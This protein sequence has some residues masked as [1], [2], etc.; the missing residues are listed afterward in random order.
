M[1]SR[2]QVLQSLG[3]IFIW[4]RWLLLENGSIHILYPTMECDFPKLVVHILD[5]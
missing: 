2:L 5:L 1:Y 3:H 4:T